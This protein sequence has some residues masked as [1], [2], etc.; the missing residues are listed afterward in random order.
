MS[1]TTKPETTVIV[2]SPGKA[3]VTIGGDTYLFVDELRSVRVE[4]YDGSGTTYRVW[5]GPRGCYG[6]NCPAKRYGKR[7]CRHERAADAFLDEVF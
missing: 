3:I 7:T 4:K 5:Q 6:C 2:T 1:T